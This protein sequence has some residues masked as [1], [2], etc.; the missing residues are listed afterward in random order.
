MTAL[1]VVAILSGCSGAGSTASSGSGGATAVTPTP[2]PT[3]TP[4]SGTCTLRA[5]Q[6]WAFAQLREWYLFPET[7]PASLDPTPY[8]S[9]S[10]YIDALTA[11]ARSQN[12]D[13]FFTYI[14]SIAGENAFFNSGASAGFG[15]RLAFDAS[16]RLF[17]VESFEGA[18]AL[19][20]GI[21]RGAQI[22]AIGTSASTLQT[23]ASL[24]ASGGG[25]AV[26]D[27]LGP[28]TAGTTRVLQISDASGTRNVTVAK[29]DFTLTPVS[30]RYGAQIITDAGRRV[31]YIN[32]RTFISTADQQ[33][34]DAFANFR[35]QGITNIIIDFRYNGGGLVS[36]AELI[37][38]LLGGGRTTSDVFSITAFRPEKSSNNST[39]N[40]APTAQSVAP[41]RVAFIGTSATASASELVINS[42][43]P[44][45]RANV[46][47]VGTN[48]YGKPVG[49]IALDQS[50]CDD[51]LRVVAFATQNANRQ[52]NYYTGLAS[53]VEASCQAP[54]D[55]TRQLGDPQ[56][57][58]TRAALN[59]L[60]GQ[61]CTPVTAGTGLSAQAASAQVF[62][63]HQLLS[64]RSP[65][66][67]QHEMPGAF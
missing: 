31:G 33:L 61:S 21:D 55:F 67:M 66:P 11:T 12:R 17:V 43:I 63:E 57:A 5:R 45:L 56:E 16:N 22:V 34:R 41:T 2:S 9:V 27:A 51:R 58:S 47:L 24:V 10:A 8:T 23:V 13:R 28:N 40:F 14:T 30:S 53:V 19:A 29:A 52:G 7:L 60:A 54:D 64:P 25:N 3:P 15:I 37:G 46:A 36:T 18:P 65:D 26:T 35:A 62:A 59:Y 32:L 6:D 38:D 1:S 4:T 20:A 44:Y 49:Q 50:A 48:T 42:M 39:R